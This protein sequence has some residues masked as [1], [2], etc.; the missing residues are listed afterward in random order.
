M[1]TQ[2]NLHGLNHQHHMFWTKCIHYSSTLPETFKIN[3]KTHWCCSSGSCCPKNSL[4][5]FFV[6]VVFFP[7]HLS[8]V[9]ICYKLLLL[10][11]IFTSYSAR[12]SAAGFIGLL[13]S[14]VFLACGR[15]CPHCVLYNSSVT[16]DISHIPSKTTR[17]V[18]LRKARDC[19]RR[20]DMVSPAPGRGDNKKQEGQIN[21][22][23]DT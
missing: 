23:V 12:L 4:P 11:K 3:V 6:V 10:C 8:P 5:H 21:I 7:F 13:K 19:I 18:K 1:M 22:G 2:N 14:F 16:G 20:N 15:S 9:C 17:N